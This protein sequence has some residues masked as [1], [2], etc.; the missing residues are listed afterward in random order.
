MSVSTSSI[1]QSLLKIFKK[2]E[3]ISYI[4][5]DID[6]SKIIAVFSTYNDAVEYMIRRTI[7]LCHGMFIEFNEP[8]SNKFYKV[9]DKEMFTE[10]INPLSGKAYANFVKDYIDNYLEI[11]PVYHLNLQKPVYVHEPKICMKILS[12]NPTKYISNDNVN[13]KYLLKIN[14]SLPELEDW[15]YN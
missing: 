1:E 11:I 8:F 13:N 10:L 4:L 12:T 5:V 6:K 15:I 9:V 3:I 2:K 14:P 7:N